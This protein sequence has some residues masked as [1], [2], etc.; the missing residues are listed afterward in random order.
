MIEN[1]LSLELFQ[2]SQELHKGIIISR[3]FVVLMGNNFRQ[4]GVLP[5]PPGIGRPAKA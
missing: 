5:L 1:A 3:T 4:T 2:L